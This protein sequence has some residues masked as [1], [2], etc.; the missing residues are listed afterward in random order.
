MNSPSF[1]EGAND[2]R[3]VRI[4]IG[5]LESERSGRTVLEVAAQDNDIRGYLKKLSPTERRVLERPEE[6]RGLAAEA[7]R[8]VTALWREKLKGVLPE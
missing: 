2:S 5:P 3:G 6:Y 8:S 4:R 1:I 7:A